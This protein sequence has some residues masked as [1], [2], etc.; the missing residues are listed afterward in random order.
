[1]CVKKKKKKWVCV[2]S[3]S[4]KYLHLTFFFF[5]FGHHLVLA[6]FSQA[7]DIWVWFLSFGLCAVDYLLLVSSCLCQRAFKVPKMTVAPSLFRMMTSPTL[8]CWLLLWVLSYN[9]F[10]LWVI[11]SPG[12]GYLFPFLPQHTSF[13]FWLGSQDSFETW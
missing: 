8:S 6:A 11:K 12:V 5:F 2:L 4:Y 9:S 3:F 7:Y 1:M 13:V 10:A